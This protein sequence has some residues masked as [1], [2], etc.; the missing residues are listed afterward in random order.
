MENFDFRRPS[1]E[2]PLIDA[3][4]GARQKWTDQ[5]PWTAVPYAKQDLLDTLDA[6]HD[7]IIIINEKMPKPR[8]QPFIRRGLFSRDTLIAANI[9]EDS[10]AWNFFTNAWKPSIDQIG[11]GLRLATDDHLIN[12]PAAS[13]PVHIGVEDDDIAFPIPFLVGSNTTKIWQ[14]GTKDLDLQIPWGLYLDQIYVEQDFPVADSCRLA[15]PY[16]LGANG[17]AVRADGSPSNS[18]HVQGQ[19]ELYQ[20]GQH[21]FVPCHRTQ[22]YIILDAF[23]RHVKDGLWRVSTDGVDEAETIFQNADTEEGRDDYRVHVL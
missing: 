15:L 3:T 14:R 19:F 8:T 13:A 21:P 5:Y 9:R 11:P 4:T 6:W 22:L 7:L 20:L 12:N 23:A 2:V 17:F 1:P 18:E 10:F 16:P